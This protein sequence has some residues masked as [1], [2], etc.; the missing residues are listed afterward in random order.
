MALFDLANLSV[1]CG[2]D[3]AADQ[4]AARLPTTATSRHRRLARLAL[5]KVMSELREGMWAV[6]QQAI[7]T[8][9]H[10]DFAAYAGERLDHCAELSRRAAFA[11]WLAEAAGR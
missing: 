6:V 11:A 9:D 8:L 1:N 2:F 4:P 10:V 5:M 3:D 7:S